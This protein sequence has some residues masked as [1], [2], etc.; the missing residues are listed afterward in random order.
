MLKAV[1]NEKPFFLGII[2]YFVFLY[3]GENWFQHLG[4]PFVFIILFITLSAI[5]IWLSFNVVKHEN[6]LSRRLGEPHGSLL[7]T[8]SFVTIEVALVMMVMT[9]GHHYPTFGRDT[10]YSVIMIMGFGVTGAVILIG[11]IRFSEQ[12]YNLRGT[13]VYMNILILVTSLGIVLPHF[14]K[15]NPEDQLT[16]PMTGYL[17]VMPLVLYAIFLFAQTHQ[18]KHYFQLTENENNNQAGLEQP[19][20]NDKGHNNYYHSIFLVLNLL[21]IFLLSTFMG[22]LIDHA[23]FA[24]YLPQLFAGLIVAMIVLTPKVV[25]AFKAA[26]H[27]DLQHALNTTLG[28]VVAVTCLMIPA[29]LLVGLFID[30]PIRMGLD[31]PEIFLLFIGF[32]ISLTNLTQNRTNI[33]AGLANMLIFMTYIFLLF[34]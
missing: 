21:P 10:V 19:A 18:Y 11:A 25:S 16:V 24:L 9:S 22:K 5:M 7:L 30:E 34:D 20:L 6:V 8:I 13:S 27:N 1:I 33:M 29:I 26:L 2:A 28:T 32:L 17:I 23:I 14:I 15:P 4:N 31:K 12:S 3:P